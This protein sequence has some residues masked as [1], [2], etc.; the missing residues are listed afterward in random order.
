M[1]SG[2]SRRGAKKNSFPN[3]RDPYNRPGGNV[4][5]VALLIDVLG[6]KRL[7][8]L[9]EIVPTTTLITVLLNPSWATIRSS[10][11]LGR[12]Y[13]IRIRSSRFHRRTCYT[14]GAKSTQETFRRDAEPNHLLRGAILT[15]W[16]RSTQRRSPDACFRWAKAV[17]LFGDR[18][19]GAGRRICPKCF[20]K[21]SS[22]DSALPSDES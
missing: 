6:A 3:L 5:G 19:S 4:T 20:A 17:G 14:L 1:M 15:G 13:R 22:S 16:S 8:L 21:S 7:G 10:R 2:A 9:R 18:N 12:A 11:L